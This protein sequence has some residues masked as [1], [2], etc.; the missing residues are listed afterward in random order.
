[1]KKVEGYSRSFWAQTALGMA[2]LTLVM[3][4]F[5]VLGS[6]IAAQMNTLTTDE[7]WFYASIGLSSIFVAAG[8][9]A[10]GVIAEELRK[11]RFAWS[12]VHGLS[13]DVVAEEVQT[14]PPPKG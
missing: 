1:M 2:G 7:A 10:L 9:G 5:V 13:A 3:S 6:A 14:E 8:L 11:L 12:Q 4:V